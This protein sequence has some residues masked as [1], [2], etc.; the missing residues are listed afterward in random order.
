MNCTIGQ[1]LYARLLDL[2]TLV[3]VDSWLL[4]L[5][6]QEHWPDYVAVTEMGFNSNINASI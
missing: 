6:D 4:F 1:I 2:L 3:V 5:L